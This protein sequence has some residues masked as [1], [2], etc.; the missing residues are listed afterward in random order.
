MDADTE[1]LSDPS[2]VEVEPQVPSNTSNRVRWRRLL[3]HWNEQVSQVT[4]RS[5]SGVQHGGTFGPED[6]ISAFGRRHPQDCAP[7]EVVPVECSFVLGSSQQFTILPSVGVDHC[8]SIANHSTTPFPR[9]TD[10]SAGS[11]THGMFALRQVF[12]SWGITC[13]EQFTEWLRREG[14]QATLPGNHIGARTQEAL[15]S[16]AC[17]EDARVALLESVF[18][19]MVLHVGRQ[20]R[21]P[22]GGSPAAAAAPPNPIPVS[23]GW[24]QLDTVDLQEELLSRVPMLKSCPLASRKV[25]GRFDSGIAGKASSQVGE[26]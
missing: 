22:F 3:L 5:S 1:S 19:A 2:A 17:V 14:F 20:S 13:R 8:D 16:R 12:R 23:E 24:A 10:T 4:P 21:V 18:V 9:R 11:N 25:P 15:L 7:P 26:R 6:W